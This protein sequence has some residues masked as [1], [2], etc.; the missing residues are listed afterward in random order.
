[1]SISNGVYIKRRSIEVESA[2]L[3]GVV[4]QERIE[5]EIVENGA[6]V[7]RPCQLLNQTAT[8]EQ[9]LQSCQVRLCWMSRSESGQHAA[10]ARP[11]R[12]RVVHVPL[13]VRWAQPAQ[14]QYSVPPCLSW[15]G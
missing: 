13:A 1:M 11:E 7:L 2:G 15:L 6:G 12:M 9:D 3:V 4:M 5:V 8:R 14:D 10:E